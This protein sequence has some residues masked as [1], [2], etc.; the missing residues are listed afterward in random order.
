LALEGQIDRD[1]PDDG[2]Y[3]TKPGGVVHRLN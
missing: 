3:I 1:L 2:I